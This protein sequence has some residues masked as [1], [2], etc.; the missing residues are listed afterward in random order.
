MAAMRLVYL[1]ACSA[2]YVSLLAASLVEIMW[3]LHPGFLKC[4]HPRAVC[5][6]WKVSDPNS[7]P[8][9]APRASTLAPCA[10]RGR[11]T[12]LTLTLTHTLTHTLTLT[13]TL[14][15]ILLHVVGQR[16]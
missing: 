5:S 8:N 12:T 14:T 11:S 10:R 13:L 4:K 3:I 6:T 1:R 2:F 9:S 15:L 16:P 7:N